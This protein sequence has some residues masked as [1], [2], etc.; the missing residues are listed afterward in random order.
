MRIAA[1]DSLALVDGPALVDRLNAGVKASVFASLAAAIDVPASALA[2]AL[3]LSA[4][5]LRN[6]ERLTADE[7]ERAYRAYRVLVRARQVLGHEEDAR[8][9]LRTPQR[10]LGGRTPLSL[11]VRDVGADEV[12]NVLGAIEDGGYL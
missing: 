1:L 7:T 4:R 3:G 10:A 6:R 5:T 2:S 8:A 11:L 9:W 12:L